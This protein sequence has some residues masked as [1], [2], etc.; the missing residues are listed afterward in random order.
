[1]RVAILLLFIGVTITPF[2]GSAA[3]KTEECAALTTVGAAAVRPTDATADARLRDLVR[4]STM[5]REMLAYLD[6]AQVA[7][8][9]RSS[10]SLMRDHRSGG[11]SRFF[12]DGGTLHGH[13]EF[14]RAVRTESAQKITLAHELGHAV[15]IATLPRRSTRALGNQLLSQIGQHDPWSAKL[16]IETP[17]AQSV[18]KVVRG[19]L[20]YGAA[21][22]GA[23]AELAQ[24]HHITLVRCAVPRR[25]KA[26]Q[27]TA[28]RGKQH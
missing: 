25:M 21:P 26:D 4:D 10:R 7:L 2:V 19:E 22:T 28:G 15:E 9:I 3:I 1:M 8:I 5:V 16:V 18:D 6:V 23:L 24:R 20:S 11:L 13:L 12:V 17:F 14:D 27:A